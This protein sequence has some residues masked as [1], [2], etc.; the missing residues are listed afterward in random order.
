MSFFSSYTIS[1]RCFISSQ[2]SLVDC[3][4]N[5]A[6]PIF[7]FKFPKITL[8]F[9][10]AI[11]NAFEYNLLIFPDMLMPYFFIPSA[12]YALFS[13]ACVMIISGLFSEMEAVSSK[14]F[15]ALINFAFKIV[16]SLKPKPPQISM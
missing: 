15:C 11:C 8:E 14:S 7:H 16:S 1:I 2:N 4:K 5:F 6:A 9:F 13:N 10:L 12:I 3:L